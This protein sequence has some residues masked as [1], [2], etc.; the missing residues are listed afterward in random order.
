MELKLSTLSALLAERALAMAAAAASPT[1]L[2]SRSR[3]CSVAF[4]RSAWVRESRVS[5]RTR[6]GV[7]VGA[8]LGVRVVLRAK[9]GVKGSESDRS[10]K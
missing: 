8:R 10:E 9:V 5:G 2:H 1:L 7:R 4:M 6:V 3:C